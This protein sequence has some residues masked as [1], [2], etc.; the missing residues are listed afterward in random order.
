MRVEKAVVK[1]VGAG[2]GVD[3]GTKVVTTTGSVVTFLVEVKTGT[4]DDWVVLLFERVEVLLLLVV[5]DE[6]SE[7]E[8]RLLLL[9]RLAASW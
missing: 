7:V 4:L 1:T 9:V 8:V 6:A 5:A 2:D 3:A